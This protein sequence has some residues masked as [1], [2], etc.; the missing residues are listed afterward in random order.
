MAANLKMKKKCHIVAPHWLNTGTSYLYI[1]L[2]R[3]SQ[4]ASE[5]WLQEVFTE[6]TS[7]SAFSKKLPFRYTEIAKVLL[8]VY[9]FHYRVLR[10]CNSLFIQGVR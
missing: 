1:V 7:E 5:E 4:Q 8:D 10:D 2:V 9:F 3:P 6:E